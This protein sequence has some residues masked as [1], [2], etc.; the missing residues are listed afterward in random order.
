MPSEHPHLLRIL[1]LARAR[2]DGRITPEEFEAQLSHLKASNPFLAL[3]WKAILLLVI[4]AL[5][6]AVLTLA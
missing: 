4:A 6:V 5:V 2:R 3:P 1:E